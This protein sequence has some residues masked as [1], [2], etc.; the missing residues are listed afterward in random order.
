MK[1][2]ILSS[3][4]IMVVM[5]SCSNTKTENNMIENNALE[6]LKTRRAIRA[7]QDKMPERVD[8]TNCRSRNLCSYRDG[9]TIP[10]YCGCHEPGNP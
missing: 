10:H 4:I 7:Y 1:L 8:S 9:K 5:A 3:T 2:N 6:V